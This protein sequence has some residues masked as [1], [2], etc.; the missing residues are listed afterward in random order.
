LPREFRPF[1]TTDLRT[2][3]AEEVTSEGL[4]KIFVHTDPDCSATDKF[5]LLRT[6]LRKHWLAGKLKSILVT[7]PLARDGKTTVALNLATILTQEQTR[8]V[9][10]IEAD[11]HRGSLEDQLGLL[12]Q[13]GLTDCLQDGVDPLSSIRRLKPLGWS[14]LCANKQQCRNPAEVL[15]PIQFSKLLNTVSPFFDWIIVDSPPV[16]PVSDAVALTSLVD[17]TLLVARAGVTP[18]K[19]IEQA[20]GLLG[21]KHIVGMVLNGITTSNQPYSS[22]ARSYR[23]DESQS[24]EAR[25]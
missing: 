24:S 19:A 14:F 16:L 4:E 23:L 12:Q 21:N 7:S 11:L 5:R 6:R 18:A 15:Q 25:R 10:L 9:L 13:P 22:S 1:G 2:F 3:R 17:G 20:V 8:R